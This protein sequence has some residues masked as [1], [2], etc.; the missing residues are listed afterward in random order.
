MKPPIGQLN[1]VDTL[2]AAIIAAKQR[3]RRLVPLQICGCPGHV[4]YTHVHQSISQFIFP[5]FKQFSFGSSSGKRP[6]NLIQYISNKITPI[7]RSE[8]YK[9]QTPQPFAQQKNGENKTPCL[10]HAQGR[11]L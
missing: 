5:S 6:Q 8:D 10:H 4:G 7:F 9:N 1:A 11:E 2:T 3:R